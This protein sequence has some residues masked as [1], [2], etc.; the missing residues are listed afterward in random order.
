MT[1]VSSSAILNIPA[2]KGKRKNRKRSLSNITLR[3]AKSIALPTKVINLSLSSHSRVAACD[4]IFFIFFIFLLSLS[5]SLLF[6]FYQVSAR[7]R[8]RSASSRDLD[9]DGCI[10]TLSCFSRRPSPS[11]SPLFLR[12]FALLFFSL[13]RLSRGPT[14]AERW[15]GSIDGGMIL[16]NEGCGIFMPERAGAGRPPRRTQARRT[17]GSLLVVAT[18]GGV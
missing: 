10:H 11:P 9:T 6:S 8:V 4:F 7:K 12:S 14:R 17:T 5:P 3:C 1:L 13:P 18:A 15:A 16:C 2:S